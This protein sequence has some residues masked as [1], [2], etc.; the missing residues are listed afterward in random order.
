MRIC[1]LLRKFVRS[2]IHFCLF[3]Y[4]QI[5][6]LLLLFTHLAFVCARIIHIWLKFFGVEGRESYFF[7]CIRIEELLWRI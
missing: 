2:F 6:I 3:I 7:V 4:I 5:F 1:E